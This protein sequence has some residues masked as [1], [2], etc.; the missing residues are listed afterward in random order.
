MDS[1]G[2]FAWPYP[3]KASRANRETR[4][5]PWGTPAIHAASRDRFI[6]VAV[7]TCCRCAFASPT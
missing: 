7:I 2:E 6:A 3:A 4:V 1:I 5:L